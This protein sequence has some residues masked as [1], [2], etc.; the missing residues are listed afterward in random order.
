LKK[1]KRK[2]ARMRRLVWTSVHPTGEALEPG[3]W[4]VALSALACTTSIL[5]FYAT[6]RKTKRRR[7]CIEVM[8][9]KRD[10]GDSQRLADE[11]EDFSTPSAAPP[12]AA[13][14]S[15]ITHAHRHECSA[16]PTP[17]PA[18]PTPHIRAYKTGAKFISI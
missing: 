3:H 13:R 7:R 6:I 2:H 17:E 12:H 5:L 11:A 8:D 9:P 4:M 14:Q 16:E 18:P 1:D 15:A 10:D